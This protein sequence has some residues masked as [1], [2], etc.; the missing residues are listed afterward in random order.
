VDQRG[1]KTLPGSAEF[2]LAV[3]C[4]RRS[5][6]AGGDGAA[7]EPI[8]GIDWERFLRLVRFHRVEGFAWDSLF[9]AEVGIPAAAGASLRAASSHIAAQS[10]LARAECGR[11]FDRFNEAGI[12]L[13]FLK[14]VTLG[15][16]AYRHPALKSAVDIDLLI[17]PLDLQKAAHLLR[18]SGYRLE[19]PRSSTTDDA[20]STWH[21]RSKE[22]AWAGDS[23]P[24][25]VDLHTRVADNPRL[26]AD[27]DVHSPRQSVE[28]ASGLTL[29]TLGPDELFAYL[30]VHG[31]AS[32]WYRLKWASDFAA[33]LSVKNGEEIHRLYTRSQA[34]GAGRAAAQALLLADWLFATL[35]GNAALRGDLLRDRANR[36]LLKRALAMISREPSE[37]T[38]RALGTL[39]MHWTPFLFHDRWDYRLSEIAGQAGRLLNRLGF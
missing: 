21:R 26:I 32:V 37:P 38:E 34:L 24:L 36:L 30:A 35:A 8:D 17:D 39:P 11:L 29:P 31:A 2:R 20:L 28:V 6:A 4:C 27:I 14:G 15:S 5:F 16:L 22:S 25:Q 10:L 1:R 3:E 33:L 23:T 12:P 9:S 18:E 7:F 19:T 13:L